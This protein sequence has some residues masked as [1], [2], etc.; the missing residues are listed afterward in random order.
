MRVSRG[1]RGLP[2]GVRM[3]VRAAQAVSKAINR[4]IPAGERVL[5]EGD[6]EKGGRLFKGDM[7]RRRCG[8]G[9]LGKRGFLR[10]R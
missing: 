6:V 5:F 4:R 2:W 10:R 9:V 8:P 1:G 7:R 3:C